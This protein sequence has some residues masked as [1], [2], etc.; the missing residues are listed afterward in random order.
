[1]LSFSEHKYYEHSTVGVLLISIASTEFM[2]Y[3]IAYMMHALVNGFLVQRLYENLQIQS[4]MHN[5]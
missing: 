3:E 4:V 2:I 5:P 1:M